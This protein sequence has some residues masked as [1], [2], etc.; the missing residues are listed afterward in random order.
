LL[1]G[2][3]KW[4]MLQMSTLIPFPG[5]EYFSSEEIQEVETSQ[6]TYKKRQTNHCYNFIKSIIRFY[7]SCF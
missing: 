1:T 5:N 2:F 4:L 6:Q 7:F 3:L